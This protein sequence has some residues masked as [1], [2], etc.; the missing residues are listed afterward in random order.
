MT[1]QEQIEEIRQ[2]CIEANPEIVELKFG[3]RV[4]V[5]FDKAE[6]ANPNSFTREEMRLKANHR[7]DELDG[8]Y[9]GVCIGDCVIGQGVYV[10]NDLITMG[11]P[12]WFKI[13]GRSIR[14]A[15][16]LLAIPDRDAPKRANRYECEECGHIGGS[17]DF[18][19]EGAPIS[20]F[21]IEHKKCGGHA[22]IRTRFWTSEIEKI[23]SLYNLRKDNLTD[24][25]DETINF[26]HSLLYAHS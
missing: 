11:K 2:K 25:S 19:D 21:W 23:I 7:I 16:I 14:L 10:K 13:I 15:D 26:I 12:E 3:C 4:E 5:I 24:Q 18:E 1:Q 22:R 17:E 8:F 6:I 9:K 20:G